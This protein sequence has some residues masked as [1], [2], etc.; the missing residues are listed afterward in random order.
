MIEAN[1]H[2]LET[3]QHKTRRYRD[4]RVMRCSRC[5]QLVKVGM[6]SKQPLSEKLAKLGLEECPGKEPC[7]TCEGRG[8]IPDPELP[9]SN[10]L[11]CPD[12]KE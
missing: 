4:V 5:N 11:W 9:T 1:G 3:D 10:T 12:C 6:R 8:R 7:D 2:Q